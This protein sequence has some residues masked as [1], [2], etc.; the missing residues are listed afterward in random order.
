MLK[1]LQEHSIKLNSK[2]PNRTKNLW[3]KLRKSAMTTWKLYWK[4]W[5]TQ[6][7]TLDMLTQCKRF[8]NLPTK[9]SIWVNSSVLW[10]LF[11]LT[12]ILFLPLNLPLWQERVR[13]QLL[14]MALTSSLPYWRCSS[15]SIL[16]T[17]SVICNWFHTTTRMWSMKPHKE[18]CL[19]HNCQVMLTQSL[20]I[21]TSSWNLKWLL[22]S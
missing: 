3:C 9:W 18:R 20:T 21:W 6:S 11:S 16:R 4:H 13:N 22:E 19:A 2:W 14:L 8:T 5:L 1:L 7:N 12:S 10:P 15:N 17:T